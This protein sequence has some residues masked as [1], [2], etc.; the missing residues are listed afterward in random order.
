MG[1]PFDNSCDTHTQRH[2]DR[3]DLVMLHGAKRSVNALFVGF[4]SERS[5]YL[6]LFIGIKFSRNSAVQNNSRPR[7]LCS[8]EKHTTTFFLPARH[9]LDTHSRPQIPSN[10]L[11]V[12]LQAIEIDRRPFFF[13]SRHNSGRVGG[14]LFA[15]ENVSLWSLK[16]LL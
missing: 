8:T 13:L 1:V 10:G 4:Q 7:L 14:V 16:P 12:C 3:N 11:S 6:E 15:L 5:Y 9:L 2:T